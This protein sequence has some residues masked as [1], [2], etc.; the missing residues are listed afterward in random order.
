MGHGFREVRVRH[1][2]PVTIKEATAGALNGVA[3]AIV[4]GLGVLVWSQSF[5]LTLVIF[6]AMIASMIIAGVA[7]DGCVGLFQLSWPRH[8]AVRHAVT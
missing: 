4:T 6:L 2:L 5:G 7:G 1:W 8:P 3:I